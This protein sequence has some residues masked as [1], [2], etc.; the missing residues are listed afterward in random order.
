MFFSKNV[1]AAPFLLVARLRES[2]TLKGLIPLK[3]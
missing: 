3:P 2:L 1:K